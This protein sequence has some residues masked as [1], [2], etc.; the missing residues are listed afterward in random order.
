M[1]CA[2]LFISR[3]WEKAVATAKMTLQPFLAIIYWSL[4]VLLDLPLCFSSTVYLV[5]YYAAES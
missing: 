1:R 2:I 3:Y 4:F 5:F